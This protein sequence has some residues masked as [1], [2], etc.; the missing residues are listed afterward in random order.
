MN[1]FNKEETYELYDS[2]TPY[3]VAVLSFTSPRAIASEGKRERAMTL[4]GKDAYLWAGAV[5]HALVRNPEL[6]GEQIQSMVEQAIL[7]AFTEYYQYGG[8]ASAMFQQSRYFSG[9]NAVESFLRRAELFKERELIYRRTEDAVQSLIWRGYIEDPFSK[10]GGS[11]IL[12]LVLVLPVGFTSTGPNELHLNALT[13]EYVQSNKNGQSSRQLRLKVKE[14]A[15]VVLNKI[16]PAAVS[17]V[18]K[19]AGS[20]DGQGMT[21]RDVQIKLAELGYYSGQIDGVVGPKTMTAL[22]RFQQDQYL[23][24]TGYLDSAT[25]QRLRSA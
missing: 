8:M 3:E 16:V 9:L 20:S 12:S 25:I 17:A 10:K 11:A 21:S 14:A 22:R 24:V 6:S 7:N 15:D 19:L 13:W 1:E 2:L 23:E 4:T 18:S 5:A